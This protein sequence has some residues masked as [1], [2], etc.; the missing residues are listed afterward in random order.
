ME[1][2]IQFSNVKIIYIEWSP[3]SLFKMYKKKN[4]LTDS[5]LMPADK[6][7]LV[8]PCI[9]QDHLRAL[10]KDVNVTKN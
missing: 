7:W 5:Y 9:I 3:Y 4:S 2:E 10:T 6:G 1:S 8:C